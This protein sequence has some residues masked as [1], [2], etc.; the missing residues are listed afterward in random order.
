MT[1]PVTFLLPAVGPIVYE[2]AGANERTLVSRSLA[3]RGAI[4]VSIP[5]EANVFIQA[6]PVVAVF[7]PEANQWTPKAH[8]NRP[9]ARKAL[10][11]AA[12]WFNRQSASL[13]EAH[14]TLAAAPLPYE[15]VDRP[16]PPI[17]A[18]R[19]RESWRRIDAWLVEQQTIQSA[20]GAADQGVCGV[21]AK[22]AS[23]LAGL[24]RPVAIR[25]SLV[26]ADFE[27]SIVLHMIVP[28][29]SRHPQVFI[30][31]GTG[32]LV[33]DSERTVLAERHQQDFVLSQAL[34]VVSG[35]GM[36]LRDPATRVRV[37]VQSGDPET[38]F[39]S[40]NDAEISVGGYNFQD[41]LRRIEGSPASSLISLPGVSVTGN[42]KVSGEV[43]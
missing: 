5:A 33:I 26:E 20:L 29:A 37:L 3:G 41:L 39:P 2:K 12:D 21:L 43:T 1:D 15:S 31:A 42:M 23:R 36:L 17:P 7:D 4:S 10:I 27:G 24:V 35:L 9:E 22:V 14:R 28:P 8:E 13:T 16:P 40:S 11:E 25:L 32:D 6:K 34:A 18:S 38:E 19:P 30:A